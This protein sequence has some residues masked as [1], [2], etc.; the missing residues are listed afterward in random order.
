MLTINLTLPTNLI[1]LSYTNFRFKT[2][3]QV[4]VSSVYFWNIRL[5]GKAIN[6]LRPS[7][8]TLQ[9]YVLPCVVSHRYSYHYQ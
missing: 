7:L 2:F 3:L 6:F 5:P 8:V 1:A 4:L 9:A